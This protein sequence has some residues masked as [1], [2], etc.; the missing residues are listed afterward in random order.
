MLFRSLSGLQKV[1]G[2]RAGH[3][4]VAALWAVGLAL[5]AGPAAAAQ[6]EAVDQEPGEFCTNTA[7]AG[8]IACRNQGEAD[9]WIAVGICFN[10]ADAGRRKTCLAR[11]EKKRDA[12]AEECG[13]IFAARQLVCKE[14]G[15]RPYDPKIDPKNFVRTIDNP[16]LPF[17]PGTRL[18]YRGKTEDGVETIVVSVSNRTETIL[19]VKCT[20]VRDTV[21]LDGQVIEDTIDWYAQDKQG[22]VWYFGEISQSFVN[23][24]LN[25][26][27]GSWRAGVDGAL[28]GIVMPAKPRKGDAYR[29][30]FAFGVAEDWVKI[31]DVRGKARVPAA[32]CNDCVVTRD[33]V[34]L[35][36]D[37]DERKFYAKGIGFILE[38]DE[39]TGERGVELVKI[40]RP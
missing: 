2:V 11:A 9:Y 16:Y 10:D 34:P 1:P 6:S 28:P 25:S 14:V 33:R 3:T 39:A 36:P 19:G 17:I 13:D 29:Q 23:G 26:L 21:T 12:S 22:N 24:D 38:I 8:T 4:I 5:A 37:A 31:L 27:A 40:E 32:S 30:E 18:T 35:E 7:K 20:V 15:Q